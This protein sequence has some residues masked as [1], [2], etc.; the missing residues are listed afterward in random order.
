MQATSNREIAVASIIAGTTLPSG[1]YSQCLKDRVQQLAHIQTAEAVYD[2][3]CYTN[4]ARP[5][6]QTEALLDMLKVVVPM[7]NKAQLREYITR[8]LA[9]DDPHSPSVRSYL[10]R[11]TAE[12]CEIG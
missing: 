1:G 9:V 5:G 10:L 2:V 4:A 3:L 8:A 6:V 7:V 11:A 12:L